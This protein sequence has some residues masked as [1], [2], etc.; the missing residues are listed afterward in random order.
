[1]KIKIIFKRILNTTNGHIIT[2][3]REFLLKVGSN[4]AVRAPQYVVDQKFI[5]K[6]P[7]KED[8]KEYEL[9]DVNNMYDDYFYN[10][11]VITDVVVKNTVFANSGLFSIGVDNHFNGEMLDGSYPFMQAWRKLASTSFPSA[12]K[13]EGDVKF[14]DWKNIK[15]L[16]SSTLIETTDTASEF[17]KLQIDLMLEKVSEKKVGNNFMYP[18]IIT[19]IGED[20]YVHGGIAMYGGG[21]NYSYVDNTKNKS[22]VMKNYHI[23]LSVLMQY[24]DDGTPDDE[25]IFTRQAILLAEAAGYQ[26]FSF[27]MYDANSQFNYQK[28]VE[29]LASGKA[30]KLPVAPAYGDLIGE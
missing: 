17:L 30:Y 16:D 6:V 13:L 4:R 9:F 26:D 12:I 20:S 8:G 21:H 23:N 19:K 24:K 25:S 29:D 1:M 22:E 14:Y 27:Y 15:N 7:T 10:N 28:Q 5:P 11:Y 3:A 2:Q 18:G